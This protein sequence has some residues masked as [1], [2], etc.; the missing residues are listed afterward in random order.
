[1]QFYFKKLKYYNQATSMFNMIGKII[2]KLPTLSELRG[3]RQ[4]TGSGL[5][6][7]Y[8]PYFWTEIQ[9]NFQIP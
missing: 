7:M 9:T 4:I 8:L 6:E 1:M 5:I 3:K 2:V